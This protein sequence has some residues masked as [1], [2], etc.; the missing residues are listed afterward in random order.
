MIWFADFLTFF[1]L[2]FIKTE[3][4]ILC[5]CI[6]LF[7]FGSSSFSSGNGY[8]TMAVLTYFSF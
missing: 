2:Q 7:D 8:T 4:F 5:Q 1:S 3:M 6:V